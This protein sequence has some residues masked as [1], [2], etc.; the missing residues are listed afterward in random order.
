MRLSEN[1]TPESYCLVGDGGVA[2]RCNKSS[3]HQP[4]LESYDES[5][6]ESNYES[7]EETHRE[8]NH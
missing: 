1:E 6:R 4:Y 5:H 2:C 7:Y 8:S 3:H